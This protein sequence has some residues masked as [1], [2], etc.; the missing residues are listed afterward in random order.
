MLVLLALTTTLVSQKVRSQ[1]M[2]PVATQKGQTLEGTAIEAFGTSVVL[3]KEGTVM[4]VGAQGA[5]SFSGAVRVYRL[6]DGKWVQLG[7]D[8]NG[9]EGDRSG[10]SVSLSAEGTRVA[11]GAPYSDGNG[12]SS[13]RVKVY[14]LSDNGTWVQLGGDINGEAGGDWSGWS[15]SL[16]A[17]GTRVAVGAPLDNPFSSSP[18]AS[19]PGRV[20]VYVL[21][22]SS[23]WM[24]LG[25]N[26]DGDAADDLSGWSV[27]LSADGTRVAVGAPWENGIDGIGAISG[28]VKVY[29]LTDSSTW[30]QLGGNIDG[31]AGGDLSGWSVSLSA[32]GT[33]VAV[34]A[35]YSNGN[36]RFSRSG[37]VKVYV[38]TDSSTWVQLGGDIDGEAR[39][40]SGWS[41]SLSAA[42]TRV[43]VG[44]PFNNGNGP[45]S[46]RIRIFVF[47]EGEWMQGCAD[48]DGE[49][50]NDQYGQAVALSADGACIAG[51]A[52]TNDNGGFIAGQVRVFS[53]PRDEMVGDP[54]VS[55]PN[56]RDPVFVDMPTDGSFTVLVA[57]SLNFTIAA[58]AFHLPDDPPDVTYLHTVRFVQ[59]AYPAVDLVA[60]D[61]RG[62]LI[63]R[64]QDEAGDRRMLTHGRLVLPGG[65]AVTCTGDA[66]ATMHDGMHPSS[67]VVESRVGDAIEVFTATATSKFAESDEAQHRAHLNL[68][69]VS[70]APGAAAARG[71]FAEAEALL[72]AEAE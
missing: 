10:W 50:A 7:G 20:K 12:S 34:G 49:N 14:V 28:R 11:V 8:I 42:G 44:A 60:D 45:N 3:A 41:V 18:R 2:L 72:V 65:I 64:V 46:G 25:G 31:D 40:E 17:A 29:V 61:V 22:D 58:S 52:P 36:V 71:A 56:H 27:S 9:E 16:S 68:R 48:I 32:D 19:N 1:P 4:A 63:L 37:R 67:C 66:S 5:N 6:A 43:A 70:L 35:P 23:T 38:L 62:G 21:T 53:C 15:V 51:G 24:Q 13:G 33:R 55:L 54:F 26:I 57:H 69:V 47:I 59:D 39:D 30:M